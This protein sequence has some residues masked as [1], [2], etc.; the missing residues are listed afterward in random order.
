M[1]QVHQ[2]V[3]QSIQKWTN[4]AILPPHLA[5]Q[6]C[7]T[8]LKLWGSS[9]QLIWWQKKECSVSFCLTS[10]VQQK[11]ES[12][13]INL[14]RV[15][16]KI[17]AFGLNLYAFFAKAYFFPVVNNES[18]VSTFCNL[19][20][21]HVTKIFLNWN[22][23][24]FLEK[25]WKYKVIL[26]RIGTKHMLW[27]AKIMSR[28]ESLFWLAYFTATIPLHTKTN[29]RASSLAD[30][31][32]AHTWE[33]CSVEQYQYK[34]DFNLNGGKGFTNGT[35]QVFVQNKFWWKV[36]KHKGSNATVCLDKLA[37]FML[38]QTC[39]TISHLRWTRILL[40]NFCSTL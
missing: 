2:N 35:K 33:I 26:K 15:Q 3:K 4:L 21:W 10:T 30:Q 6:S 36:Q 17:T 28:S 13:I 27:T 16:N 32:G 31:G 34:T 40:F 38:E 1:Q 14:Y 23:T 9:L 18:L 29:R 12:G 5:F 20:V 25:P 8:V 37:C 7:S 19:C 39:K 22:F 24:F 11:G